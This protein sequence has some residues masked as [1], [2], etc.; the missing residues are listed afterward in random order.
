MMSGCR[1][2][3]V[4]GDIKQIDSHLGNRKRN[5]QEKFEMSPWEDSKICYLED[6]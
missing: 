2:L 6:P 1:E 4:P 5:K 3:H